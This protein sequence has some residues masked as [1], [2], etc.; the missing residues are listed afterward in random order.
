[1]DHDV[2]HRRVNVLWKWYNENKDA[3]AFVREHMPSDEARHQVEFLLV[4]SCRIRDIQHD[5]ATL[6]TRL[7]DRGSAG[8]SHNKHHDREPHWFSPPSSSR[9]QTASVLRKAI[10]TYAPAKAKTSA[11]SEP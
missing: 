8:Q 4:A 5:R 1:M 3:V 2:M 9:P 6:Q 11:K 10:P 7:A